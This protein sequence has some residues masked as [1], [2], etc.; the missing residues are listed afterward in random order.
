MSYNDAPS[1]SHE[2]AAQFNSITLEGMS[3]HIAG[4]Q[5]LIGNLAA[6]AQEVI[7]KLGDA[8]IINAS[9]KVVDVDGTNGT[10]KRCFLQFQTSQTAQP[11]AQQSSS[12]SVV[13]ITGDECAATSKPTK[14]TNKRKKNVI[15]DEALC[16]R[17]DRLAKI[18]MGFK[19]KAA[20][21]AVSTLQTDI[22]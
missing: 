15:V 14:A 22:P 12:V 3:E 16:R 17:S 7:P 4:L 13:E 6:N 18:S 21:V 10:R 8:N 20:V 1:S 9:C 5:G 11:Q 2:P 19:D